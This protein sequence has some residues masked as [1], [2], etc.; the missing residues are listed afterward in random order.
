MERRYAQLRQHADQPEQSTRVSD[1][2]AQVLTEFRSMRF[3]FDRCCAH[4]GHRGRANDRMQDWSDANLDEIDV[5]I[6]NQATNL[7]DVHIHEEPVKATRGKGV[8]V[9]DRPSDGARVALLQ[10]RYLVRS[11]D[12]GTVDVVRFTGVLV[13][14]AARF[15]ESFDQVL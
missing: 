10:Q 8:Y 11:P 2:F 6:W 5:E 13:T 4:S 3:D 9:F 15:V 14:L 1:D 7:R 12:A